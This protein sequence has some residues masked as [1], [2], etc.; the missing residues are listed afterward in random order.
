M[1]VFLYLSRAVYAVSV[2][3]R[4]DKM[5]AIGIWGTVLGLFRSYLSGRLQCVKIRNHVSE[6]ESITYSVSQG[7]ALVQLSS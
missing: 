7:I 6:E 2:P 3:I 5:E 4:L 1:A